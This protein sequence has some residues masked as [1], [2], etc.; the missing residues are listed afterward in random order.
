MLIPV[1]HRLEAAY[2]ALKQYNLQPTLVTFLQHSENLTFKVDSRQGVYLLRLHLPR[3]DSFGQVGE[4]GQMVNAEM[5]WLEALRQQDLPV[6]EPVKNRDGQYVCAVQGRNVTLLAWQ[7]GEVL[8]RD[9]ETE[10][11]AAQIGQLVGQIHAHSSQW[12]FPPG[13]VRPKRDLASFQNAL[14]FLRP[15]VSD[16][17]ISCQDY[18]ALETSLEILAGEFDR[19]PINRQTWGLLHGDLHRGNFLVYDGQIR[20]IDFSMCAFG[21]FAFDLGTCLSN[22][23][24]A[25]HPVFLEQ[26]T[27]F[28]PLPPG[29]ERLI[30]GY[31]L[32][33]YIITFSLWI[34]DLKSQEILLQRVSYI[35]REYASRFNRDER[36]WF[37]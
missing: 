22:V 17:R 3:A 11:T 18:K 24:M 10:Q 29:Y 37:R 32:A 31:F 21:H 14:Q 36:F 25:F 13:F 2:S 34:S 12:N 7:V 5:L 16:G 26:Y 23:R 35:V 4:N 15:A 19:L 1:E 6:P 8:T 9:M 27:R 33:S 20:L 30:E 28:F